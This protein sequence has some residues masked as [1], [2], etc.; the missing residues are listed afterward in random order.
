MTSLLQNIER[1]VTA[2]EHGAGRISLVG[3]GQG[4]GTCHSNGVVVRGASLSLKQVVPTIF[5]VEVRVSS[6]VETCPA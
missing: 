5:F 2:G 3:T 4:A 6:D 1:V